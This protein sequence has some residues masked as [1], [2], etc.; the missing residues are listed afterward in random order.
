MTRLRGRAPRGERVVDKVPLV[1][2][3]MTT[4]IAATRRDEVIAPIAFEGATDEGMFLAYV[5]QALIPRLRP[6]DIVVMDNL[7]PHRVSAVAR[8]IRKAG[9]GCWYLPPYSP[10]Y[11][12][13]EKIWAKIKA[14]L[15]KAKARTRE[16]LYQ[17]FGAALD[18]VTAQD[19]QNSFAHCGYP[20][21][22][23]CKAL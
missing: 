11:N 7:A 3:K 9:A 19:C 4:L 8:R 15:R 2:W 1:G 20:A 23:E 10:D 6:G 22:F 18:V 16:A 5:E 13:I 14:F 17:A 12:P 21:T